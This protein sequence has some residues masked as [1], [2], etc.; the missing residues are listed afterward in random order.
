M[1]ELRVGYQ[2]IEHDPELTMTAYHDL[3]AGEADRCGCDSCRNFAAQRPS[4]FPARFAVLQD[5]LKS[6]SEKKAEFMSAAWRRAVCTCTGGWFYL[7]GRLLVPGEYLIESGP[8]RYYFGT[9]GYWKKSGDNVARCRK[10]LRSRSFTP[11]SP[12]ATLFSLPWRNLRSSSSTRLNKWSN[13]STM[14]SSRWK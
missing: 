1:T 13:D 6:T 2:L 10:L 4:A 3:Q 14:N 5:Q 12:A 11:G 9:S 7:V 8:F